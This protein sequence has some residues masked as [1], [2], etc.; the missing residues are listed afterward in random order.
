MKKF[1]DQRGIIQLVIIIVLSVIILSLLGVSITSLLNNKTLRENF[2][3]L[4]NGIQ[5]LWDT[6][7]SGAWGLLKRYIMIPLQALFS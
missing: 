7:A 6:Y 3:T 2:G 1:H 5:W 4:W